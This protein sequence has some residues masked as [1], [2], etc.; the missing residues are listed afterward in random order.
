VTAEYPRVVHLTPA[1]FGEGGTFGGAERYAFELARH[2][3]RV[4]PTTLVSFSDSPRL[5]TSPEGLRVRMLGPAWHVR[6]Q[7]FNPIHPGILRAVLGA[8]VIH[9]HQPHTLAAE[10]A[11][12]LARVSR[13][14]VFTSD[15]GGGGWGFSSRLKTDRWFH[16]HLHISE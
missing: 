6:G 13:R 14:R 8:D 10:L 4:T 2:M 7:R 11:A 16:G 1:L 15:L 9:C 12:L 3:A 5:F